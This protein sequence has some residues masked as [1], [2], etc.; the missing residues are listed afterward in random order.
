MELIT[1]LL[2]KDYFV[3]FLVIGLGTAL[4]NVRVKGISFDTS[5]VIFVAIFFGYLY[6]LYGVNFS[7]PPIIQSVGLVLFIYTIGMQAG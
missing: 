5:A 2:T 3:L 4:G 1:E 7:I 6:N